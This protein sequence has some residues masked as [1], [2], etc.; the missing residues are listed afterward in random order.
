MLKLEAEKRI[1][2]SF[3]CKG[4]QHVSGESRNNLGSLY[5]DL[6]RFPDAHALWCTLPDRLALEGRETLAV[7]ATRVRA[8]VNDAVRRP[9]PVLLMTHVAPMRVAVLR[10]LGLPLRLYKRVHVAN[11]DC[12]HVDQVQ[13][14]A[15]RLGEGRSMR[16]R[17]ALS[18]GG[19]ESSVA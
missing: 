10:A 15:Y 5:I 19:P 11:G 13:G 3:K 17:L 16:E 4:E 9:H 8:V 12:V 18:L 1:L 6:R 7:L 14:E 2:D